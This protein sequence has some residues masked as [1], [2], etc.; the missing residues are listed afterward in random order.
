MLPRIIARL[1]EKTSIEK[2]TSFRVNQPTR[3]HK[4]VASTLFFIF[5]SSASLLIGQL[6][7]RDPG[8]R[9]GTIDAGQPLASLAETP[10]ATDFFTNGLSRFTAVDVV[11]GGVNNGLGPRFNTNTCA[12]CHAQP[13]VGV[14]SPSISA[15]PFIGMN[16]EVQFASST[17]TPPRFITPDGPILEARF[18]SLLNS[19]ASLSTITEGGVHD[20]F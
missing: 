8:V 6:N 16:P 14:T 12:S 7:P 18:K 5:L 3:N 13:S 19:T 11:Q 2:V 15:F 17:N 1:F 9:G 10:G 20:L 4:L